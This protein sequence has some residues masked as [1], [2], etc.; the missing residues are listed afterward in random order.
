TT[1]MARTGHEITDGN[2][3]PHTNKTTGKRYS[4]YAAPLRKKS[5]DANWIIKSV[6]RRTRKNSPKPIALLIWRNGIR[7]GET[8]RYGRFLWSMPAVSSLV[9]QWWRPAVSIFSSRGGLYS[10]SARWGLVIAT[11]AVGVVRW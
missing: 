3:I 9:L 11:V 4:K 10:G 6:T 7:R 2:T 1:R 5:G 8:L